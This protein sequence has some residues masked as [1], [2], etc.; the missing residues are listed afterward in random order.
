MGRREC[1]GCSAAHRIRRDLRECIISHAEG[2]P[3]PPASVTVRAKRARGRTRSALTRGV[4]SCSARCSAQ[5]RASG[6]ASAADAPQ[7]CVRAACAPFL[8]PRRAP[9][10]AA[11]LPLRASHAGTCSHR[12]SLARRGRRAC[13]PC[14]AAW[15]GAA[16]PGQAARVARCASDAPCSA[17]IEAARHAMARLLVP[18]S[19]ARCA[20]AAQPRAGRVWC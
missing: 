17:L 11:R 19:C 12:D 9:R 5:R 18:S 7:I 8:A 2:F 15:R 16:R 1:C 20:A 14:R 13:R 10:C 4:A 6:A 3:P